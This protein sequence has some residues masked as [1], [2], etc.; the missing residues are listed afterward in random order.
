MAD[1]MGKVRL[2]TA[3]LLVL[4][5]AGL[6]GAFATSFPVLMASRIVAG[7]ASGGL[8]PIA[9]ALVGD[10]VPVGRR[11]VA[12]SRLLF[13][14]MSGNLL[15]ASGAGVIGDLV[16]WRGVFFG[17]GAG[18]RCRA[19]RQSGRPARSDQRTAGALRSLDGGAELP[20]DLR[21]PAGKNLLRRP[22]FSKAFSCSGCFPTS[23]S[24]SMRPARRAPPI[25]GLVIAGFGVGGVTYTLM[26]SW[27]LSRFGE[28]RSDVRR[29]HPDGP[30]ADRRRHA[31]WPGRSSSSSSC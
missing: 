20:G 8:F 18:R 4:V 7:I 15:G 21:Q 16:G 13:A 27:L 9:L 12:I 31:A 5:L 10:L 24:C 22:C 2:M 3:C 14:G 30:R 28:R 19:H 26:V 29:R 11:Q 1:M 23:R 17:H 25:A 6:V